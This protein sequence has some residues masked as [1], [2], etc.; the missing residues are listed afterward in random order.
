MVTLFFVSYYQAMKLCSL[1]CRGGHDG[2]ALTVCPPAWDVSTALY[3]VQTSTGF[4]SV[5][6]TTTETKIKKNILNVFILLFSFAEL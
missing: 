1:N 5:G 2:N 6:K 4:T 3:V